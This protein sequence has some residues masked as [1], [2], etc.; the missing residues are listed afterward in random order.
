MNLVEIMNSLRNRKIKRMRKKSE[1]ELEI[2][3]EG[4]IIASF[5]AASYDYGDSTCLEVTV[6]DPNVKQGDWIE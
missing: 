2:E 1:E 5:L 6:H 3:F 4:G